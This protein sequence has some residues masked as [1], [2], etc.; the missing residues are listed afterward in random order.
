ME[1]LEE[2]KYL[3]SQ[4]NF[5]TEWKSSIDSINKKSIGERIDLGDIQA[6]LFQIFSNKYGVSNYSDFYILDIQKKNNKTN[7]IWGDI[8]FNHK[9][10]IDLKVGFNNLCGSIS[11]D[12][13]ENFRE[14]GYY[15]CIDRNFSKY[16][17]INCKKLKDHIRN[18]H[19]TYY[20]NNFIGEKSSNG[21]YGYEE[22]FEKINIEV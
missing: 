5:I 21:V 14:D 15:L 22:V 2:L 7:K 12:S 4:P 3:K 11:R 13:L 8:Y 16:Y 18:G 10:Y 20:Y 17:F 1:L 19:I 9:Y 6:K